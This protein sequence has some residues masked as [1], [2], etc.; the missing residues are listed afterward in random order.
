MTTHE[1]YMQRA[2]KASQ[3]PIARLRRALS[4]TDDTPQDKGDYKIPM[5][6]FKF[7]EKPLDE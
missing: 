1:T 2:Q 3:T 5:P 4:G 6:R 7:L